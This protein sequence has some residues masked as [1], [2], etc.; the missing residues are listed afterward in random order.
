MALFALF[1][2]GP[3]VPL[4]SPPNLLLTSRFSCAL[5]EEAAHL[6]VPGNSNLDDTLQ[7]IRD[8][9]SE[10]VFTDMLND[11]KRSIPADEFRMA[12]TMVQ[13]SWGRSVLNLSRLGQQCAL[14]LHFHR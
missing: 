8:V 11:I 13:E 4:P 3:A 12:L 2:F 7:S 1:S 5:P 14:F 9:L 6:A 10:M